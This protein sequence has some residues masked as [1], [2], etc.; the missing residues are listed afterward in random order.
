M[1]KMT[2][3]G[4]V[5]RITDRGQPLWDLQPVV[6][7]KRDVKRDREID[8]MLDEVLREKPSSIPLSKI[9]EDSRR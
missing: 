5:V 4:I 1:K 7:E 3:G 2:R 6:A 8:E 9:L